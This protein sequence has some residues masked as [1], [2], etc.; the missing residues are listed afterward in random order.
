MKFRSSIRFRGYEIDIGDISVI[1]YGG[2]R[3]DKSQVNCF[4]TLGPR[5]CGMYNGVMRSGGAGIVQV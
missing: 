2:V 5:I 3:L 1:L 4:Y